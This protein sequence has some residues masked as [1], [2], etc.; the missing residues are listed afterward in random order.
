LAHTKASHGSDDGF[1]C[2]GVPFGGFCINED[3]A[4]YFLI[5][6]FDTLVAS[7]SSSNQLKVQPFNE[8]LH[9]FAHLPIAHCGYSLKAII[10]LEALSLPPSLLHQGILIGCFEAKL[11]GSKVDSR[12]I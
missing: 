1:A 8:L 12:L 2:A 7:S 5:Y 3:D 10:L 4:A 9:P 11:S 6:E